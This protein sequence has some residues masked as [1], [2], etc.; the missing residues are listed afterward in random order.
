MLLLISKLLLK[1]HELLVLALL[2]GVILVR[3]FALLEGIS[4]G[5]LPIS[6]ILPG[7]RIDRMIQF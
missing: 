3:L 4:I 1:L 7:S 6:I 5:T 2:D